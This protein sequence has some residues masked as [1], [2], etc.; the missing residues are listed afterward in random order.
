[1]LLK[2]EGLQGGLSHHGDDWKAYEGRYRPKDEPTAAEKK[3]LI[4]FTRL[5]DRADDAAFRKGIGSF[6][7]V[8]AFLRFVA[9]NALLANLDS[10]L[11]FGHNYYLYLV[12]ATDRFVFIPWDCDL[13]L[14][15][16]PAGGTPEQQVELSLMHPHAG[17]NKLIDRLLA[18]DDVKARYRKILEEMAAGPFTKEKLLAEL[19]AMEAAVKEPIAREKKAVAARKEGGGGF[20]M[21]PGG[22]A[23][24]GESLPPRRFVEK[25]VESLAAQLA[26][27]KK[28]YVPNAFGFGP[29]GGF[30]GPPRVG[31]LLPRPVQDQLKLT[32][33]QRRKLA[34]LQKEVD[35]RIE[36]LL[37]EAQRE[38][39]RR[40]RAARP[41]GPPR[42]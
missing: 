18:I 36:K 4:E 25:R 1:M 41:G 34:E 9:A 13:S 39:L 3:R 21:M 26:D 6:L 15:A 37:D 2:P 42:P 10:Y 30:G 40:M 19:G 14:A 20:G 7:D 12:P 5:I 31:E 17:N 35:E 24:F 22:G 28:G 23:V 16:W 33:D 11:G 29:P 38:A 8:D 27:K 32:P